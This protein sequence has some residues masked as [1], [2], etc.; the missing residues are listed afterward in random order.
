MKLKEIITILEAEL[1]TKE[2]GSKG[3]INM[4]CASDLMSDVLTFSKSNS[5]LLTSLNNLHTVRTAEMTEIYAV[6]F[7]HGK[8]PFGET[9]ELA[10]KNRI[11]LLTTKL[12]MYSACGRLY[13]AGLQGC[14]NTR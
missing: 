7:V 6:C 14:N 2:A 11:S 4:V 1:I 13:E 10:D 8:K 3:E 9:V 5:L 12:S